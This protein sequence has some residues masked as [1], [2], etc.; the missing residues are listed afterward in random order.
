[1]AGTPPDGR[2]GSSYVTG[3][4]AFGIVIS[5][6]VVVPTRD[7]TRLATDI[8]RLATDDEFAKGPLPDSAGTHV[9]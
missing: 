3:E 8:Y 7:G 2:G 9:L 4:P 6:D 5:K 1:M